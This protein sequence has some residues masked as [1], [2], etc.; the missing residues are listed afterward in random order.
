MILII[1]DGACPFC[2]AYVRLLRLREQTGPV[3][4]LNARDTDARIAHY[5]QQGYDLDQGMLVVMGDVVHAGADALHLL[6]VC[7]TPLGWFNRCNVWL[8]SSR[9]RARFMYPLL[10]AGRRIAL[11]MLGIPLIRKNHH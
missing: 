11:L 4:L 6:A 1:H 5:Q 9:S 2:S 7:S 8:F 3:E 10:R